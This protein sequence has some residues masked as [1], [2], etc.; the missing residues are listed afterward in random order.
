MEQP[1]KDTE[2]QG[3]KK[4]AGL[5]PAARSDITPEPKAK[6]DPV[7]IREPEPAEKRA[8]EEAINQTLNVAEMAFKSAGNAN[9]DLHIVKQMQVEA[10]DKAETGAVDQAAEMIP[11]GPMG[12]AKVNDDLR[13]PR[14]FA[15]R[16]DLSGNWYVKDPM[17]LR[18]TNGVGDPYYP[19]DTTKCQSMAFTITHSIPFAKKAQWY[20]VLNGQGLTDD[21]VKLTFVVSKTTEGKLVIEAVKEGK[22]SAVDNAE[23]RKTVAILEGRTLIVLVSSALF[24]GGGGTVTQ[25]KPYELRTVEKDGAWELQVYYAASHMTRDVASENGSGALTQETTEPAQSLTPAGE[26][27]W[28]KVA[29]LTEFNDGETKQYVADWADGTMTVRLKTPADDQRLGA[30]PADDPRDDKFWTIFVVGSVTAKKED[31]PEGSEEQPKWTY[32]AV[33]VNKGLGRDAYEPQSGFVFATS[34]TGSSTGKLSP[35]KQGDTLDPDAQYWLCAPFHRK[36][37][38][39][40]AT[41]R[42]LPGTYAGEENN[43]VFASAIPCNW[44]QSLHPG[45][46]L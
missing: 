16:R 42:S 32:T 14:P 24:D 27:L 8:T 22:A 12:R 33:N 3:E 44:H 26:G 41:I 1:I 7:K 23:Q 13:T 2:V 36:L 31:P 35:V 9:Q 45:A 34:G 40:Q 20:K 37:T 46:N 25:T 6:D 15:L 21:S 5:D 11:I 17:W 43:A 18:D 38:V 29:G 10:A 28:R 39:G 4:P 19:V 30:L